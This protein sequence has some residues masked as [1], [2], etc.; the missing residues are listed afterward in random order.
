[1][2]RQTETEGGKVY[3]PSSASVQLLV[4]GTESGT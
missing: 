1:M 2:C 4:T 3:K